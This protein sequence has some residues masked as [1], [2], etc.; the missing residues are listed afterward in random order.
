MYGFRVPLI[1]VS[2]YAKAGYASHVT[3]DFG[4]IARLIEGNFG[5]PSLGYADARADEL[6]DYFDFRHSSIRSTPSRHPWTLR[7]F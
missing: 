4:S 7:I 3:H 5:L 1:V 6:C 2:P